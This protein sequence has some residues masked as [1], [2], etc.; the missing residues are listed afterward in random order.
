LDRLDQLELQA[1]LDK[2][3]R[4]TDS[5]DFDCADASLRKA[6]RYANSSG[7]KALVQRQQ[8]VVVAAREEIAERR[9][10][11]AQEER[12]LAEREERLERQARESENA[13]TPAVNPWVAGIAAGLS[14]SLANYEKVNRIH[15]DAMNKVQSA[16]AERDRRAQEQRQAQ[17]DAQAQRARERLAEQRAEI[18]RQRQAL[19]ARPVAQAPA[20]A[21]VLVPV[22]PP[23][24]VMNAPTPCVL[25]SASARDLEKGQLGSGCFNNTAASP[26]STTTGANRLAANSTP[27]GSL[28]TA[29]GGTQSG[30]AST[31]SAADP[32]AKKP[33]PL[34]RKV[35]GTP[36]AGQVTEGL[37]RPSG[38]YRCA[39]VDAYARQ[40]AKEAERVFASYIAAPYRS[41][42]KCQAR[43]DALA[44]RETV[45]DTFRYRGSWSCSYNSVGLWSS[46]N[47]GGGYRT[48]RSGQNDDDCTCVTPQDVPIS[49]SP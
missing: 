7:D 42:Q 39:D 9:R 37:T 29:T 10:R 35:P 21:R 3:R 34:F 11:L 40:H 23:R 5:Q 36:P 15:T 28:P 47:T 26:L 2:A 1:E 8:Q 13:S 12:E 30:D 24:I 33:K 25:G 46:V 31:A 17:G 20:P 45:L 19:E 27:T 22:E 18:A 43:C 32:P 4:C 48:Y 38:E 6:R 41:E 44:W 16:L 49:F 14:S